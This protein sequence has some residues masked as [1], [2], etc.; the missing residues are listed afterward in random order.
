MLSEAYYGKNY[1][2][3]KLDYL[4]EL[5]AKPLGAGPYQFT[6]YLPGQEIRYQANEHYYAGK[7]KTEKLI[8]KIIDPSTSL[9]LFETGDLDYASFHLMMIRFSI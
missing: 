7:P 5:Y 9:Q 3:G 4:K 1:Q 6:E 2:F 8:Y